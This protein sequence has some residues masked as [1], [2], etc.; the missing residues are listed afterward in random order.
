[1]IPFLVIYNKPDYLSDIVIQPA[2][3][4]NGNINRQFE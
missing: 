4:V 1:M 2:E 3:D